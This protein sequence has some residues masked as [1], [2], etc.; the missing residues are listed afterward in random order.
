MDNPPLKL[1]PVKYNM[2]N[3]GLR[4]FAVHMPL[5]WNELPEN[6]RL[7][8]SL[9]LFKSRLKTHHFKLAFEF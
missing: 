5:M 6:V 9:S 8:D 2:M 7:S 3:Y 4:S 1:K